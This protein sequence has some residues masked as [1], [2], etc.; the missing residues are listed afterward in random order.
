[1]KVTKEQATAAIL[2]L[3]RRKKLKAPIYDETFPEQC[4]FVRD[5]SR[6]VSALCTRRAGKSNGL[7]YKFFNA[8]KREPNSLSIY[9]A[10]TRD[11]A[12]NIMWP[13]FEEINRKYNLGAEFIESKLLI[14]T[15]NGSQIKLVG[16]DQ[17]GFIERL[18]G[19]KYVMAAVDE[20]QAFGAH[21]ESLIDEVLDPAVADYITGQIVLTGTPAPI[22]KGYFYEATQGK[23]G[24][25]NHE[26]TVYQNPYFPRPKEYVAELFV[27]KGWNEHTPT[28]RREWLGEWVADP[29]SLVYRFDP[30]KNITK[31]KP[32][33]SYYYVLGVDLGYDPDPSAFVLC[34]YNHFDRRM[35]IVE[36]YMQNKMTVSDVAERIKFYLKKHP[37]LKIVADLGAQGKMIGEEI[38]QRFDIPLEAADKSGKAGFIEIMNSDFQAGLIQVIEGQGLDLI[39]E[40]SSLIWDA[41]KVQRV[42]DARYGNHLADGA[43]YAWR[44]CYNYVAETKPKKIDRYS[45]EFVDEWERKEAEKQDQK[46]SFSRWDEDEDLFG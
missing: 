45:E 7:G 37:T 21:I 30:V 13:I 11:S 41:D 26:W 6:Y 12:K 27:K 39:D 1:M 4:E 44:Y 20:A 29:D 43:L 5:G 3:A 33:E 36:T 17:R 25:K 14:K 23:F 10:L 28:Y 32:E 15:P 8:A 24:F 38:R 18:R 46:N 31:K 35:Y 2:E 19:P 42:E 40:W 16:A 9:I 34:A 22:P